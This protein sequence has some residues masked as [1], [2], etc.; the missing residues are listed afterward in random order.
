[1]TRREP[2]PLV[3]VGDL[4][5]IGEADYCYG[6]GTLRL[7]I[8]ERPAGLD[9]PGLEWV[10]LT[11]VELWPDGRAARGGEPRTALVRVAALR[12]RPSGGRR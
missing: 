7:R 4:V 1:M 12:A 10:E 5:E 9:R 2:V 3:A 11:G 8:T 6:T